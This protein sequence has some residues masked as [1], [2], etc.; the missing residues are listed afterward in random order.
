MLLLVFRLYKRMHLAW[1]VQVGSLITTLM[2]HL[3]RRHNFSLHFAIVEVFV[4]IVLLVSHNDF[5]RRTDRMTFKKALAFTAISIVLVVVN[6]SIGL[7]IMRSSIHKVHDIIDAFYSSIRLLIFMDTKVLNISGRAGLIYADS[8]ILIN[9]ICIISSAVLILK[10][11]IYSPIV[12]KHDKEKVRQLVMNFGQ[13][14]LS[15]LAIEND[16]KYLFGNKIEGVCAYQV[17]GNVFVVC[18]DMICNQDDGFIFLNEII[19]FCKQNGYEILFLNI[20]NF[21]MDLLKVAGFGI[22]K[23]GEDACFKLSDYDLAGGKVAKVRAAINHAKNCG[24]KVHEY[25]PNEARDLE[26]EVQINEISKEWLISK[27]GEELGF[28]IGGTGLSN[29]LDRRYFYA[30]DE[31]GKILGFVVFLPYLSAQGYIADVTR[32]RNN[33]PQGVIE[34]IIYEAFMTMKDEGVIWGNMG[35]S[36]LYNVAEKEEKILIEKAFSFVFENMNKSYDFKALHHS[37]KKYAPTHWESRYLAHSSHPFSLSY[38]YAIL[39]VQIPNK[40]SKLLLKSILNK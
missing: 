7:F 13:N 26:V 30:K 31:S 12:N 2:F 17:A 18:G 29:P 22:I 35:L 10:P 24:I 9:W 36:P 37:K 3:I 1:I 20:T 38:G 16:K 33:A 32:R 14:P 39:K 25:K 21:F 4:L 8:L 5:C 15:Y 23:Y 27:G 28:M 40:M 6:A 19:A 11:L 34:M